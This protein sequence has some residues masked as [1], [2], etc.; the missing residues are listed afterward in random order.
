[1]QTASEESESARRAHRYALVG[2]VGLVIAASTLAV[3][4]FATLPSGTP[5]EPAP[6]LWLQVVTML[7]TSL[8]VAVLV[9]RSLLVDEVDPVDAD[10]GR[11]VASTIPV[12]VLTVPA[13]Q[14]LGV[15]LTIWIAASYWL[16]V[17]NRERAWRAVAI[18]FAIAVGVNII[19]IQVL[20]VPFP[21]GTLTGI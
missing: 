17:I 6:G 12:L 11:S 8:L 4:A 19:F 10:Q 2:T 15:T 20:K 3:L 18:S 1:M 5:A 14:L 7:T 13:L 21:L 16:L 9:C